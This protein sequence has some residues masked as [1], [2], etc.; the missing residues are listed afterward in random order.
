MNKYLTQIT[1]KVQP[2]IDAF[3]RYRITIFIVAF[4]SVYGFLVIKINGFINSEPP[5]DALSQ[6]LQTVKQL[7]ID[8]N[9]I[10]NILKLEEQNIEV[11]SLFKQARE[12]PFTE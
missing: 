2:A 5:A 4:L 12:N 3:R 6:Q 8:Q 1:A 9:A 7:R 10:D 11:Q